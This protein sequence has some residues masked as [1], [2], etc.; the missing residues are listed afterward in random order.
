MFIQ[1]EATPN[2]ATLKFLPGQPV[3]GS[4]P[5]DFRTPDEAGRSPLAERLFG[6]D[7]VSGVF[8]GQDFITVTKSDGE[9]QHLKPAILGLIMEHYLSG[10]PVLNDDG[11]S[12][13]GEEERSTKPTARSSRPSRSCSRPACGRRSPRMAATSPSRAI[14]RASSF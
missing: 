3:V 5:H 2:P 4:G 6:I 12:A 9:W 1:T 11:P 8:L 14:A 10:E 7:G 13:A